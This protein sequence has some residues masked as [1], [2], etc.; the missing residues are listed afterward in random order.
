MFN[1]NYHPF[2]LKMKY[3]FRI[4]RGA[5]SSTPILLTAIQ[6]DGVTGYGEASMPPLYGESIETATNFISKVNLSNFNNPF[7]IDEIMDYVDKIEIGNTAAKASI[8]IALHDIVGKLS[9]KPCYKLFGLPGVKSISTSKTI[10]IDT[11]E[12]IKE[13]TLEAKDFQF[14]KIKL[15]SDNDRE[16]M[17]AVRSVSNQPLYV[18]AN[19]GWKDKALALDK[20]YWLKEKGVVFVEQPMPVAMEDE[21]AWL[22]SRSPLPIVGDEGIQRLKDVERADNFY[23]GINIK[24]V[25]STGLNEGLKM[26]KLAKKKDLKVMLGCMSETSCLISAAF[27]LASLADWVDLDGNLGVLNNPYKGIETIDGKLINNDIP[28]IGLI[29][30]ESAWEKLKEGFYN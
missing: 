23:H 11:P 27:H 9:K 22:K 17:D 19:Q 5:R 4:S 8:D 24:L 2:N 3:I 12:I 21:M 15:G 29:N 25:K 1:I 26:A 20:I 7:D 30:P 14:L 16:V 6:F 28:G 10:S 18:D 13:R